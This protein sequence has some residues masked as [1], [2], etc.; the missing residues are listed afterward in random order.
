MKLYVDSNNWYKMLNYARET[1]KKFKTEVSGYAPI[2][3]DN[4]SMFLGEPEIMEQ[5]CT[6]GHTELTE[7]GI[8]EYISRVSEKNKE[9]LPDKLMFCWWHSHHTMKAYFS[10]I[11]E[12]TI[13]AYAENGDVMAVVVNNSGE[14]EATFITTVNIRG[15]KQKVRI[16]VEIEILGLDEIRSEIKEKVSVRN[17]SESAWFK[18]AKSNNTYFKKPPKTY[19]KSQVDIFTDSVLEKETK[20]AEKEGIVQPKP[21]KTKKT[22]ALFMSNRSEEKIEDELINNVEII[23][24]NYHLNQFQENEEECI[25]EITENLR[26]LESEFNYKVHI[27]SSLNDITT[28]SDLVTLDLEKEE[29]D[30]ESAYSQIPKHLQS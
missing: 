12:S 8:A 23:I 27:P 16:P 3:I 2:F 21:K 1:Y 10:S 19:K 29:R 26:C 6:A 5:E 14:Y 22:E 7:E 28:I 15:T 17:Y 24:E 9:S 20:R 18:D 4:G 25:S 30:Y 13:K 11:D